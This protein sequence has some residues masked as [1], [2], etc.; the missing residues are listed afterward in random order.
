MFTKADT[1]G[2]KRVNDKIKLKV[3]VHGEKMLMAEFK[4]DSGAGLPEHD[5]PH[6]QTGYLISGRIN[7]NVQGEAPYEAQPGD[8]WSIPGGV[9]HSAEVLED[10][11]V[12][13]VF[14]PLREDFL[15]M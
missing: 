8:T 14:H 11:V 3:L 5:H 6:E 13:E 15:A 2:Y 12:I 9:P 1:E 7:L 4:M 10:S